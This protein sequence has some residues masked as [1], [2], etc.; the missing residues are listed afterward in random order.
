MPS[1]LDDLVTKLD[2]LDGR[3]IV[4]HREIRTPEAGSAQD[5][6]AAIPRGREFDKA[7][8]EAVERL[9]RENGE[10]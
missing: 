6:G 2:A 7:V 8:G 3:R 1:P 4:V 9:L 5:S 10:I